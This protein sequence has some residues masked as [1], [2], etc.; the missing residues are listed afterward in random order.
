MT[1]PISHQQE[2]NIIRKLLNSKVAMIIIS[3]I[4]SAFGSVLLTGYNYSEDLEKV[5]TEM[6]EKAQMD[7]INYAKV[8][9]YNK[10]LISALEAS[11][12]NVINLNKTV[13]RM[14]VTIEFM[15]KDIEYIRKKIDK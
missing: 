8:V 4:I 3:M 14:N 11:N 6:L 10:T 5:K 9:D 12:N 1:D 15:Q 7:S 13:D 2:I